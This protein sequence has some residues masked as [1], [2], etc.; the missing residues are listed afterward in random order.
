MSLL[1]YVRV[2]AYVRGNRTTKDRRLIL[3]RIR[4]DNEMLCRTM[5]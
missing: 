2:F 1:I 3:I 4:Q 5:I